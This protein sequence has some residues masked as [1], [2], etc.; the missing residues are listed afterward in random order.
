MQG[1][2]MH[3]N[4]PHALSCRSAT[5][6]VCLEGIFK[7]SCMDKGATSWQLAPHGW[8]WQDR[9]WWC[10]FC[11]HTVHIPTV[12]MVPKCTTKHTFPSRKSV[13]P[14]KILWATNASSW[15]LWPLEGDEAT[16]ESL[17]GGKSTVRHALSGCHNIWHQS[18][19][20]WRCGEEQLVK[21]RQ[22]KLGEYK[23]QKKSSLASL[24]R[25]KRRKLSY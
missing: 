21:T 11:I 5:S 22:I 12:P 10:A 13:Q 16:T 8:N 1:L 15:A 7:F 9:Q 3:C 17:L 18:T 19:R 24:K 23:N 4:W 6:N 2:E 20:L 25:R 14:W